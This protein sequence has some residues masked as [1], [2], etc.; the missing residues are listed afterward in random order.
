MR[1]KFARN[2]PCGRGGT[3]HCA[4][5]VYSGDIIESYDDCFMFNLILVHLRFMIA[6][7]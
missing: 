3:G 4:R 6:G 7:L 2:G 1:K 5:V